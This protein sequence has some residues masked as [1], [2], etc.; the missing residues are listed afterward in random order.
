MC[1]AVFLQCVVVYLLC[2]VLCSTLITA[3]NAQQSGDNNRKCYQPSGYC[4]I[5]PRDE[6]SRTSTWD[7][8]DT[9]CK[10]HR[11]RLPVLRIE[12]VQREI[13]KYVTDLVI[14][15]PGVGNSIFLNAKE[16]KMTQGDYLN[17]D[18]TKSLYEVHCLQIC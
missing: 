2:T 6:S 12:A 16:E 5:S 1:C 14:A 3:N 17:I 4:Y 13:Q 15:T 9:W 11:A 7:S 10:R 8:A 18:G